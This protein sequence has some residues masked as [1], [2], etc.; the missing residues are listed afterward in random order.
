MRPLARRVD[1]LC[2]GGSYVNAARIS[3]GSRAYADAPEDWRDLGNEPELFQAF[4]QLWHWTAYF[5]KCL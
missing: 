1:A 3:R 2:G 5:G 4:K